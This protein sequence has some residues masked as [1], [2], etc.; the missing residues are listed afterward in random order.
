MSKRV[1]TICFVT[2]ACAS[3]GLCCGVGGVGIL[4][5]AVR[6]LRVR[7]VCGVGRRVSLLRVCQEEGQ[8]ATFGVSVRRAHSFV[9]CL[10]FAWQVATSA[11]LCLR[12]VCYCWEGRGGDEARGGRRVWGELIAH[13]LLGL[14]AS[15][16]GLPAPPI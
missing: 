7:G 13:A 12:G 8:G 6:H 15:T 10:E 4:A 5:D 3:E 1:S 14:A 11:N 16:N 2:G 9:L